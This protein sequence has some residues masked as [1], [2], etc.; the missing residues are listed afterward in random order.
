MP[1]PEKLT[2]LVARL[3]YLDELD[4]SQ[5][6]Q[7]LQISQA[8]VSRLLVEA[9]RKRIVRFTVDSYEPR[10]PDLERE[11]RQALGLESVVVVRL[12]NEKQASDDNGDAQRSSLAYFS[13]FA[14]AEMIHG[15]QTLAVAGGRMLRSL[16]GHLKRPSNAAL[17]M[18]VIQAMGNINPI[19][20]D[21]DS[22]EMCRALARS[23]NGSAMTLSAPAIVP[24]TATKKT[25]MNLPQIRVVF[26]QLEKADAALVGI[27]APFFSIHSEL[28]ERGVMTKKDVQKAKEAGAVAEIC[29]RYVDA[30]GNEC[31]S[32]LRNR[33]M[34]IDIETLRKI[35]RV[36]GIVEGDSRAPAIVAI[37][38]GRL[39]KSLVLDE[40]GAR[41]VLQQCR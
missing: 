33:T 15:S 39:V 32:P 25:L 30:N 11:V 24:D 31:D 34:S 13:R 8:K 12:T 36:V 1:A 22:S 3:Y 17:P 37:A 18:T 21:Y 27:G 5:I 23:W 14:A 26:E 16:I 6:A 10:H 35:P 38:R 4:Q 41:A 2:I 7:M 19:A 9:R 29:G 28:M 20:T 40:A